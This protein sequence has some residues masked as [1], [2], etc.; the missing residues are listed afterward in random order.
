MDEQFCFKN[1]DEEYGN[2][3]QLPEMK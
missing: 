3:M 1:T 2:E